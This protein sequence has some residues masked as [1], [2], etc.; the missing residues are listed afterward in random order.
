[1]GQYRDEAGHVWQDDGKG[2]YTLVAPAASDGPMTIGQKDPTFQYQGDTAA[3]T[4]QGKNLGNTGQAIDNHVS[5]ATA[6]PK[7]NK[8]GAEASIEGKKDA[9][10]AG[11][12]GSEVR[13]KAIKQYNSAHQLDQTIAE[14]EAKFAAGPGSTH[15]FAG[16]GDYFPTPANRQFD[17]A[18][19]SAR[20]IVKNAF[21]LTG[22]EVN[23]GQE[24]TKALGPYMPQSSD[25]DVVIKD[26]IDRMKQL[27]DNARDTAIKTLGGV[28]DQNGNIIPLSA[29]HPMMATALANPATHG[30][31][32]NAPP[33]FTAGATPPGT[34]PAGP[35]GGPPAPNPMGMPPGL[36]SGPTYSTTL[37]L[38]QA[39]AVQ[40][41]FLGHKGVEGMVQAAKDAGYDVSNLSPTDLGKWQKAVADYEKTGAYAPVQPPQSGQRNS[42][43]QS[44]GGFMMSPL[45]TG[46]AAATNA[47]GFGALKHF[48]PGQ[49]AGVE[50]LNPNSAQDWSLRLAGL[51]HGLRP[52]ASAGRLRPLRRRP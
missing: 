51:R 21:D 3:S 50:A 35:N 15:G 22:G 37:D 25:Y 10:N 46:I 23:T 5:A 18:S 29:D 13:A 27:R 30:Q 24:S 19:D 39:K 8:A 4:L 2:G 40:D 32:N 1:M 33:L 26:A 17:K 7:I 6:Q 52:R 14:L 48:A 9:S 41:A 11:V 47:A 43:D 38:K 34:P 16:L 45:G 42:F 28:P 31:D 49:M 36:S 20:N 12:I 44:L